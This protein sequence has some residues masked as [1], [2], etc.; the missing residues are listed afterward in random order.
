MRASTSPLRISSLAAF[1]SPAASP[2]FSTS[3]TRT[4]LA[5]LRSAAISVSASTTVS[6]D[7]TDAL[8][9][10]HFDRSLLLCRGAACGAPSRQD[11]LLSEIFLTALEPILFCWSGGK[12]SAMALYSLL[13]QK[14]FQ[15]AA[16]LTTVTETYHR[17]AMHGVRRALPHLEARYPR[18]NPPLSR[19]AFPR[20]RRLH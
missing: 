14:T 1:P 13:Q 8:Y 20:H 12:D 3:N 19:T 17:I 11:S 5:S 10:A 18:T 9:K 4:P 16:L 6:P 2:I 7:E 15:V